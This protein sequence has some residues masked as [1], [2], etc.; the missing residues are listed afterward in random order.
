[1]ALVPTPT[2]ILNLA[3]ICQFLAADEQSKQNIFQGGYLR[4][5]LSRLIYVV[6]NSVAWLNSVNPSSDTL[7]QKSL[8][9]YSLLRPFWGQAQT[10]YGSG[11]TGTIVN[12]ATGVSSTIIAVD[13]QFTVGDVGALMTAGDTVLVLSYENVLNASV[14]IDYNSV[15]LGIGNTTQ[16]SYNVT[17]TAN[18]ITITFNQAV[19]NLDLIVIK[20]LEYVTI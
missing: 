9:L 16:L 11:G 3:P 8:Y 10:I 5:G 6:R 1:M 19:S 14:S 2:E 13:I 12:P 20:F 7:T 15:P 18:D 17:Y 4:K